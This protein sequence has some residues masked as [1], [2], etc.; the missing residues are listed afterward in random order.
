MR[1]NLIIA[2]LS[3]F[4]LPLSARAQD[5]CRSDAERLCKDVPPG[6]G[7]IIAC[8]KSHE[9]ELSPACKEKLAAGKA[10]LEKIKEACQPDAD[11]FCKGIQ[12][13]DGRIAACLKSHEGELAPAC[14]Q[15]AEKVEAAIRE[16]HEACKADVGK[17]CQGIRPGEGRIL[18]C[19]KSHEAELSA[20][21]KAE[22]T[23]REKPA[24]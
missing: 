19:L 7:R 15:I 9:S 5:A 18:A 13:G 11:K 6:E 2:V 1:R 23:R 22:F 10:K 12:P 16:V 8:L 17:F 4:A 3:L 14:R 21:C 20:D 24:K